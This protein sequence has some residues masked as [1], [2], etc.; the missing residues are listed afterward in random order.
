[1]STCGPTGIGP[2]Q[3]PLSGYRAL[4]LTDGRGALAGRILADLGVDVVK[5]EPPGGEA[6]RIALPWAGDV[7][8]PTRSLAW[9][10]ANFGKRSVALDLETPSGRTALVRL[11]VT[12]DFL[13]ESFPPGHLA[14]RGLGWE[15]LARDHPALILTSIT[16]FGQTGPR[17]TWK[18]TDLTLMALGG[19]ALVCGDR[20][21]PPLRIGV[22]QAWYHAATEAVVATLVAHH[23]RERTG[24]G[25]WVDVA[26]QGVIV[27]TLM[28]ETGFPVLHD[29]LFPV[30]HGPNV[31]Y[32][33]Y[34]RRV[35]FPVKDGHVAFLLAGGAVGAVSM[36]A[37]I[38]WMDEE[39][40]AAPSLR[41]KA[42]E[43]WDYAGLRS[44]GPE[45]AQTEFDEVEA[46][47]A[48][49]LA[50]RTKQQLYEEALRR[51]I[52]LAPVSEPRDLLESVQ[53]LARGFFVSIE[54]PGLGPLTVPGPFARFSTTPLTARP[55]PEPGQHTAEVLHGVGTAAGR[56]SASGA[57]RV[58]AGMDTDRRP[59]R[60]AP[61][62]TLPPA[63]YAGLRVVDFT[64]AAAG[65]IATRYLAAFGAEVIRVESAQHPDPL[66]TLHPW[67]DGI[68]GRDRSYLWANYN[69]GKLGITLNLD[70]AEGRALARQLVRRA[71]VVAESFTPGV[72]ARWGLDYAMLAREQPDLVMLSTCQQGQSGPH[73][74]SPGYG[75]LLSGLAGFY[76]VTGWPDREPA[77]I[78]G[79]YTDFV[80]CTLGAIALLAALDHRRRTGR[81]QWIDLSQLEAGLQFL[82]PAL[83]E[84]AV[85]GR[86]WGRRGN[87]DAGACPHGIYPC[88]GE[89]RWVALAVE[90]PAE[91][92][93]LA[94]LIGRPEWAGDPGLATAAGR[95][96]Q[97]GVIDAAIAAWTRGKGPEAAAG[98]LQS[99]AIAAG[100]VASCADLHEDPQLRHAGFFVTV[101]HPVMGPVP[102]E[103]HAFR[104]PACPPG[105]R[106]APVWGEHNERIFGEVLGLSPSEIE[107]LRA[108]RVIW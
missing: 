37:L 27:R 90:T 105:W 35:I 100:A 49:F 32:G 18:A 12:A 39:G 77:M 8:G 6:D 70:T 62:P 81:G 11:V 96:R 93:A 98:A 104:L 7:A 21:R 82:G 64:W 92:R 33:G 3:G 83:L 38:A 65:P 59:R 13:L 84:E 36:R 75:T 107:R 51:R 72:M 58:T 79:A 88:A 61:D 23:W 17:A 5:I 16:A 69:A 43:A 55:A 63:P 78:Y 14:A 99:R 1:M 2:G 60:P 44:L 97:S 42:W 68:P 54:Q 85:D 10:P 31:A 67:K 101:E 71:D 95:G 80:A 108:A 34:R 91:W 19:S 73:A 50:R 4:D 48:A 47:V 103:G 74:G 28:S 46:A 86:P 20:D 106:S 30:R 102:V 89:E 40:E 57:E 26:A 52:M 94:T 45:A 9:L 41:D 15:Q 87:E 25:Q 29:G 53:L 66:R 76:A 56:V 24:V 22:P